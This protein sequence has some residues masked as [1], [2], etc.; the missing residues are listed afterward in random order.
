MSQYTTASALG[1]QVRRQSAKFQD[2]VIDCGARNWD[3][4]RMSLVLADT[5]LV[6]VQPRGLDVWVLGAMTA[7]VE[8]ANDCAFDGTLSDDRK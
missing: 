2:T 1:I 5:A 8:P 7:L 6:P 4:L 3:A